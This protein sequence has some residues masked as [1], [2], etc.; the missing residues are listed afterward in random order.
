[1]N[2]AIKRA[3]SETEN[4]EARKR[5]AY[6]IALVC[7]ILIFILSWVIRDPGDVF[8]QVLYPLFALVL[9]LVF[10][11]VWLGTIPIRKLEIFIL[12]IITTII[13]G[14]LVWHFHFAGT[15]DEQLI[16]LAAGHYWA[17][18]ILIVVGFV[19]FDHNKG[20]A[21][22]LTI[23]TLSVLIAATGVW[24]DMRAGLASGETM[25]YLVRIHL[26]LV[27]LLGL[28]GAA[29]TLRDKLKDALIRADVL[30]QLVNTDMLTGL[31]N[32]RA[33]EKFLS[34]QASAVARYD[35]KVSVILA[36]VD[37]FKQVND[38]FG[39]AAGDAV[40]EG[41]SK[42][43][44]NAVRD[45]DLVARWG[46]EEFLIV[47]QEI[48]VY[49]GKDLARRCA[50]AVAG[51]P[52]A[53]INVTMSFGVSE[54]TAQDSVDNVLSRADTL[55]YRAKNSGRNRIYS[56]ADQVPALT[57]FPELSLKAG[58]SKNIA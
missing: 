57:D 18:G 56:D 49:N 48:S 5:R 43:L 14:R 23:I 36:D 53:G 21:A 45:T 11:L 37:Y 34:E 26:F 30:Q 29:T 40:L 1:M 58:Q 19:M 3:R 51:T 55:L 27:L 46:G 16:M 10:P 20:I 17:I 15:I 12:S 25:I 35:R 42:I 52:I 47:A 44:L 2:T 4:I 24:V 39:H 28:T 32:R 33:A 41:I 6:L 38:R 31:A 7:G 13:L 50:K 9:A 8:I 22:G 54:L